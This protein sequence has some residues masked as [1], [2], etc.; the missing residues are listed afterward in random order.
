MIPV[1]LTL[2]SLFVVILLFF[3]LYSLY[4]IISAAP[5][6][7]VSREI[8]R[9]MVAL[10]GLKAGET[11]MD[12]G[13]GDGRVVFEGGKVGARSI[14][15]EINP[16]LLWW[17]R[18]CSLF[19]GQV[20][21]RFFNKNLWTT[22]LSTVDVLTL[23]FIRGKMEKLKEKVQREMKPGSRVVSYAFTFP[24]WQYAKK[25]GKVY[26][27]VLHPSWFSPL[28]ANEFTKSVKKTG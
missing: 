11:H 12:L 3:S 20:S 27:Y 1:I 19:Q 10:S 25:D 2:L 22:D 17:S 21:V 16:V 24:G 13:S 5:Y 26:L 4:S 15:I 18:F 6:V 23:Y 14:G 7:P 8:A 28:W 9:K